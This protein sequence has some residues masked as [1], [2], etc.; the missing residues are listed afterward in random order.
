MPRITVTI[1]DRLQPFQTFQVIP[2]ASGGD[3]E[4]QLGTSAVVPLTAANDSRDRAHFVAPNAVIPSECNLSGPNENGAFVLN[5][6]GNSG[7]DMPNLP[8]LPDSTGAGA[9]NESY[10][11]FRFRTRVDE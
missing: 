9:P 4:F 5:L 1:C 3:A 7:T 10:G 8:N 2:F 6:T 11:L